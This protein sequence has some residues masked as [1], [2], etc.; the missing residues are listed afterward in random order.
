MSFCPRQMLSWQSACIAAEVSY[1][2]LPFI[3][4]NSGPAGERYLLSD[5]I[6]HCDILGEAAQ[7]TRTWVRVGDEP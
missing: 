1:T 5:S 6:S 2:W 7:S 4:S 3:G